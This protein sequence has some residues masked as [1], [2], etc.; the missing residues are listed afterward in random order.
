MNKGITL[1]ELLWVTTL[2][3]VMFLAVTLI[4][5]VA[6][7][8]EATTATVVSKAVVDPSR[9][10]VDLGRGWKARP[11]FSLPVFDYNIKTG[12][13]S[14]KIMPQ[15]GYGVASKNGMFAADM[16]VGFI[17]GNGETQNAVD[18]SLLLSLLKYFSFGVAAEFAKGSEPGL[19]L[20]VGA[21]MPLSL[22]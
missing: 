11:S 15:G 1:I 2:T 22:E 20:L 19:D 17:L 7:S 21:S 12:D 10:V 13:F 8:A 14:A 5:T 6:H 9:L 16:Y 3:F 18:I 4:P